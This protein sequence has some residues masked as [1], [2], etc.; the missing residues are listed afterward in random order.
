MFTG[1]ND[2]LLDAKVFRD[3]GHRAGFCIPHGAQ[4]KHQA[5][6]RVYPAKSKACVQDSFGIEDWQVAR[7]LK[8]LLLFS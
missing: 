1:M 5:G 8:M 3:W 7:L 4:Y 2:S 6:T